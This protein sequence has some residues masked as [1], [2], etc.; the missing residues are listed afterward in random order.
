MKAPRKTPQKKREYRRT[1]D[2]SERDIKKQALER[3][4]QEKIPVFVS[5]VKKI[6][7]PV[8]KIS[9]DSHSFF[10]QHAVGLIIPDPPKK[11]PEVDSEESSQTQDSHVD[12]LP[13]KKPKKKSWLG[14]SGYQS[15]DGESPTVA[16]NNPVDE[17]ESSPMLMTDP[18]NQELIDE[19]FKKH[20]LPLYVIS[21]PSSSPHQPPT[22]YFLDIQ[23]GSFFGFNSGRAFVDSHKDLKTKVAVAAEKEELEKSPASEVTYAFMLYG[24]PN[25]AKW[26]KWVPTRNEQGKGL[27]MTDID[28]HFVKEEDVRA[29]IEGK[30][31]ELRSEWSLFMDDETKFFDE[32]HLKSKEAIPEQASSIEPPEEKS[33]V[34]KLKRHAG[35]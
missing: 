15:I 25:A 20:C 10:K 27:K 12:Q 29:K 2:V 9:V 28:I 17:M 4:N 8:E 31:S 34:H 14:I 26:I 33:Y 24:N 23:V 21:I 35:K 11:A 18:S 6:R 16:V 5:P 13:K 1:S 19:F 30:I 7:P 32:I 3:E 22:R